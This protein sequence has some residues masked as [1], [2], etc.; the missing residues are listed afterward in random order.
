MHGRTLPIDET[1]T[2]EVESSSSFS[3]LATFIVWIWAIVDVVKVPD[4]SKVKAGSKL[5]WGARDRP[6]PHPGLSADRSFEEPGRTD[7]FV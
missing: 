6:H 1:S 5:V 7:P 3:Q 4:D 2:W